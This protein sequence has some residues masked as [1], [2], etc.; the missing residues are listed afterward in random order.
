[1]A[2]SF[3]NLAGAASKPIPP[4]VVRSLRAGYMITLRPGNPSQARVS[5]SQAVSALGR[6]L[7]GHRPT[8]GWLVRFTDR[9]AANGGVFQRRLAWLVVAPGI[10]FPLPVGPGRF[11]ATACWFVGARSGRVLEGDRC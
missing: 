1:M 10:E 8:G 3:V 6:R 2:A 4:K 11:K 5:L 7:Q 9:E